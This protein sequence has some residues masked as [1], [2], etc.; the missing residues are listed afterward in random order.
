MPR[1]TIRNSA[2]Y[3][4][5]NDD[6]TITQIKA[7]KFSFASA[8][9][10]FMQTYSNASAGALKNLNLIGALL[11]PL[12][13]L[14]AIYYILKSRHEE[15]FQAP[16][17]CPHLSGVER[18]TALAHSLAHGVWIAPD[19]LGA[20]VPHHFLLRQTE[21]VTSLFATKLDKKDSK[22]IPVVTI[23]IRYKIISV[24]ARERKFIVVPHTSLVELEAGAKPVTA[25]MTF[26]NPSKTK[27]HLTFGSGSE[28]DKF[29]KQGRR[30]LLE[31][32]DKGRLVREL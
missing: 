8:S 14:R 10:D 12:I 16:S 9:A 18:S 23:D 2:F 29:L 19:T 22:E 5:N 11:P 17:F 6:L 26:L 1:S 21:K 30:I 15:G 24:F 28:R 7:N 32:P 3:V 25:K 31:N 20:F 4:V 13:M 27:L